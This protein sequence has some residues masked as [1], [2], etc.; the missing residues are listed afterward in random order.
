MKSRIASMFAAISS[1]V[2]P[3]YICPKLRSGMIS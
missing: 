1:A 3:G 2:Y